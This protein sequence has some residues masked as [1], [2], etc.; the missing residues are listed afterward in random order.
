MGEAKRKAAAGFL[1][2]WTPFQRAVAPDWTPARR[3]SILRS[4]LRD[5]MDA[6]AAAALVRDQEAKQRETE[7]WRNSRYQVSI[8]RN[9]PHGFPSPCVWLA[10][11]RLD[12]GPVG[13]E[14]FRDFQRIKNELV[15]PECEAFEI[16]PAESRLVDSAN[17]YHLHA[18]PDPEMRIPAGYEERNVT[19]TPGAGA[20]QRPFEDA[21]E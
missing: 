16:Y 4:F 7:Y 18:F 8:D 3:T 9:P 11:K 17:S 6:A 15:G 21:A 2:S 20:V 14:R 12:R 19:A 10:I 13:V 5:G 1:P